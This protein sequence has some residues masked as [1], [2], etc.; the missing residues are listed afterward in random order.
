MNF[1]GDG[2][3][4]KPRPILEGG[5]LQ[6]FFVDLYHSRKL[7]CEPT[8]GGTSNV[9]IPAGVRTPQAIAR[10]LPKAFRVT[11]FLGGNTSSSSGDF[12]FGIRGQLLEYGQPVQ[13]VSEMNIS[14]N[15][16]DL[17]GNFSEAAS[18]TWH[19]SSMRVPTLVFDGVQF[20][21]T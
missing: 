21:G 18:D 2:F 16:R 14:G 8:T 5:V 6:T 15:I 7:D 11:S 19:W 13:N 9:V 1:D 20:S 3:A 10:D 12:S 17:L 4:A